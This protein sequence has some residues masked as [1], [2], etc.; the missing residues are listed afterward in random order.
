ML[1]ANSAPYVLKAPHSLALRFICSLAAP[2][3]I[4]L[5]GYSFYFSSQQ[6]SDTYKKIRNAFYLILTAVFIDAIIWGIAPF[7]TFDVLYTI[8]A[9]I[10]FNVLIRRFNWVTKSLIAL[11]IIFIAVLL[12]SNFGYDF[13]MQEASLDAYLHGEVDSFFI[14]KR[15]L[16]DGWFPVFPWISLAVAGAV[17][18][19]QEQNLFKLRK[20]LLPFTAIL[21][22]VTASY[23]LFYRVLPPERDGYLELFY[24]ATLSV[25]VMAISFSML[26]FLL[27]SFFFPDNYSSNNL[28]RFNAPGRHSLL[29]Y[30]LHGAVIHYFF[31]LYLNEYSGVGFSLTMLVFFLF[32]YLLILGRETEGVQK[33][34]SVLP[35]FI[36]KI[37]GI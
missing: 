29:V 37:F 10:I 35:E 5:S 3:F 36:R 32:F 6:K 2:L 16:V 21:F 34:I 22:G 26:N 19:E 27:F 13:P 28:S 11:V 8:S 33:S 1:V 4:F 14:V 24:P 20:F 15:W 25:T 17:V 31:E 18:A 7:Q 23:V 9:G 30:I 12:R